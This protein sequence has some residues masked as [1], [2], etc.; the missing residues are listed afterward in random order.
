MTDHS[1][2]II[3]V[4]GIKNNNNH[5]RQDENN[6]LNLTLS[7]KHWWLPDSI[8]FHVFFHL[9]AWQTNISECTVSCLTPACFHTLYLPAVFGSGHTL[10]LETIK[11]ERGG[12]HSL[13][14]EA[15]SVQWV[16]R[17]QS[18]QNTQTLQPASLPRIGTDADAHSSLS[19]PIHLFLLHKPSIKFGLCMRIGNVYI[20]CKT[21]AIGALVHCKSLSDSSCV[22]FWGV[23]RFS[24]IGC[25]TTRAEIQAA[26]QSQRLQLE[27]RP[28]DT[29]I[30][31][32]SSHTFKRR[33]WPGENCYHAHQGLTGH[34]NLHCSQILI[35]GSWFSKSRCPNIKNAMTSTLAGFY[36]TCRIR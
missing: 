6:M 33:Q 12:K 26:L 29:S 16:N 2:H 20:C 31:G 15:L 5:S 7:R 10:Q 27:R 22:C 17:R 32:G 28:R 35:Q 30:E 13:D 3:M 9:T 8:C 23:N 19:T 34:Q 25:I 11:R 1:A 14:R 36:T 24:Q 21:W 4:G 18:T